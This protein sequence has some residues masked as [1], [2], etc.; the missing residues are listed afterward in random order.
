MRC[1]IKDMEKIRLDILMMDRGIAESRSQAQRLI[2]AGEVR[3]SGQIVLKPSISFPRDVQIEIEKAPQFVSRGGE[4]LEAGLKAFDLINLSGKVCVDVGSSTG[5][6]TDC[7]IQHHAERVY[8]VDVGKGLLH[9]KLRNHPSVVVMETTN[10]RYLTPFQQPIDLVTVDASFITLKIL[11]PTIKTWLALPADVI[12]LIKPQFEAGRKEA[13]RG[14]GVIRDASVHRS[15]LEETLF[16]STNQGFSIEGLIQS[17]LRGPKGNIEFLLH[18]HFAEQSAAV[19]PAH[20]LQRI[21]AV[22]Q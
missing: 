7:L 13:A 17:P 19:D 6:F 10:A 5:G 8:A 18:L 14:K 11:L 15:I 20:I 16:F 12:A 22:L 1:K 9:W 3:V 4:K 21:E 2:M